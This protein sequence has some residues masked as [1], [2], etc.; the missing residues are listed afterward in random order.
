VIRIGISPR[1]RG[2]TKEELEKGWE[3]HAIVAQKIPGLLRYV[4]NHAIDIGS[5]RLPYVGHDVYAELEFADIAAMQ[6]GYS[7][8]YYTKDVYKDEHRFAETAHKAI[9]LADREVVVPGETGVDPV[10]L[11]VFLRRDPRRSEEDFLDVL[12]GQR[13]EAVLEAPLLRYERLV[14]LPADTP[15]DRSSADAVEM[16]GFA[17]VEEAIAFLSGSA[18]GEA[19]A[20]AMA[21]VVFGT[22]AVLTRP[23]PIM[24]LTVGADAA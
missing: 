7:S 1:L 15:E 2:T 18:V 17:S 6:A 21:G 16:I 19:A 4:Q 9:V 23:I 10:K 11:M 14:A 22:V 20:L 5:G 12:R 3:Q 24:D 13:Q 8:D